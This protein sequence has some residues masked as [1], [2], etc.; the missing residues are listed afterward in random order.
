MK[1]QSQLGVVFA[2]GSCLLLW[3]SAF[4][5]IRHGLTAFTPDQ[6]SLLRFLVGS[7]LLLLI[8]LIF[9]I[10]LPEP[11]DIPALLLFGA[12]G[13][14]VYHAALNYGEVT[15]SSGVASLFVS[16]TPIFAAL[17]ALLVYRERLG[18]R[19][20]AGSLLGFVG[21]LISS[22]GTGQPFQWNNGIVLILVASF[23]ES[24]YFAFQKP[25]VEKYGFLAF[26]A[27]SVWGGTLFMLYALPGLG[28]A[29]LQ[30]PASVSLTLLYLGIFPTVLAYLAL[31]YV[32]ARVGASEATSSLY[33]T[34]ALAFG[35][36]WIWLGEVP[37]LLSIA[38]GVVTLGG[39]LA[40]TTGGAPAGD[41]EAGT[42]KGKI[43][44]GSN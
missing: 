31:A 7:A 25:Y 42:R 14:T 34:P 22:M 11:K 44:H 36:A 2:Q 40:A 13:F 20:W 43:G 21:V 12:S 32:T 8:A 5:G 3:A 1:K 28:E 39:V 38:G 15:V 18:L 24:L 6:L 41:A 16:T 19:G 29:I 27:Y 9:R 37:S 33:L 17:L 4:P 10:R 23:S 35:I 26:T 30:A